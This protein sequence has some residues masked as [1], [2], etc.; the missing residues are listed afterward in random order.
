MRD[1]R[2]FV[3]DPVETR[4]ELYI[5]LPFLLSVLP[6]TWEC[7]LSS[8]CVNFS[9]RREGECPL[10][11]DHE[12]RPDNSEEAA[13]AARHHMEQATNWASAAHQQRRTLTRPRRARPGHREPL[14]QAASI[15]GVWRR[16]TAGLRSPD[17]TV[18]LLTRFR[19]R[20][21]VNPDHT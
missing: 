4:G 16:G 9:W 10:A 20:P 3:V 8:V 14:Q 12:G 11:S 21:A 18:L 15:I 17:G 5:Q 19:K 13:A 7:E 6:E 1:S 2:L